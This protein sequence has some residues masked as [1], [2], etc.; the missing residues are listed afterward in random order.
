MRSG[1]LIKNNA[2]AHTVFEFLACD[3]VAEVRYYLSRVRD[4][5]CD[6]H[7]AAIWLTSECGELGKAAFDGA[8]TLREAEA[9]LSRSK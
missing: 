3:I 6:P 8:A 1:D 5:T 2:D 9:R 4:G 7:A